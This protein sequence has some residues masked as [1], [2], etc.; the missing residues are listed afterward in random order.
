[1]TQDAWIAKTGETPE[2]IILKFSVFLY[3]HS[4]LDRHTCAAAAEKL[5][6]K[7]E[8]TVRIRQMWQWFV[9]LWQEHNKPKQGEWVS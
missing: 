2:A 8:G 7:H 3:E 6:G 9:Q 5:I 4:T 1:M